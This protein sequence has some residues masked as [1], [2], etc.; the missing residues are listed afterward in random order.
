MGRLGAA[1][2]ARRDTFAGIAG[3]GDLV[4]TCFSGLSRNHFVGE[5]IG[6][7]R[8]LKYVIGRMKMVAE[9]VPTTRSVHRLAGKHGIEM[10]IA[11]EIHKVLFKNK[12]PRRAVEHLMA[13][14]RKRE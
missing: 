13:R 12:S 6:K 5:A 9:G 14:R 7:G 2:G 1:M 4:T 3:L 8:R 11:Q 10:P